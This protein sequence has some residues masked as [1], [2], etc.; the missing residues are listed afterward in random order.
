[1]GMTRLII[2]V[3]GGINLLIKSPDPTSRGSKTLRLDKP[4]RIMQRVK[5]L[6]PGVLD[7]GITVI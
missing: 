4:Q 5:D 2:R 6:G 3:I 7:A 1:M